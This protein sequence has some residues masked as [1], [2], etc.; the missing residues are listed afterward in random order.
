VSEFPR[1]DARQWMAD[2][3]HGWAVTAGAKRIGDDRAQGNQLTH[4]DLKSGQSVDW[5]PA[6]GDPAASRYSCRAPPPRPKAMAGC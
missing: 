2:Y 3:R 4:Y 6:A 1:F 5:R